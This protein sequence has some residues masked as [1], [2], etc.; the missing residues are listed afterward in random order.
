MTALYSVMHLLVDG[1]CALAM[2]GVYCASDKGY[3]YL[4]LYNFCAFALQMPF[5]L[6]LDFLTAGRREGQPH[7]A[8]IT[9][10]AGVLCTLAGALTHPAVLGI[11]NA[12]FHVGG[13]L[14][15]IREDDT[16]GWRGAGLG[17]F[18]APGALGLFLG[19]QIARGGNWAAW[20][21]WVGVVM[22]FL[23]AAAVLA[24]RR[25]GET[26]IDERIAGEERIEKTRT[27]ERMIDEGRVRERESTVC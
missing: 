11:G 8:S 1:V 13:G 16:K 12:L 21:P 23:C 10:G 9:A 5:G 19:A 17:V 15:T 7:L 2:F 27:G 18:V 26:R 25:T 14:G 6:L 4:L 3:F 22:I 20:F 24:Q